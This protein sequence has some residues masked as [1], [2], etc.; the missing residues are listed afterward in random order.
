LHFY[1]QK[2]YPKD[3]ALQKAKLDLLNSREIEPRFKTP[4]YWAHLVFIGNY[5]QKKSSYGLWWIAGSVMLISFF[6][7]LFLKTKSRQK[8]GRSYS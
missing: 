5:T 7:S 2:D 1:L 3:E 6:V 8:A 4:N